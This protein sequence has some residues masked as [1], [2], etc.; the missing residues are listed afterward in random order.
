MGS[1]GSTIFYSLYPI[2]KKSFFI[3]CIRL[4]KKSWT[5]NHIKIIYWLY[6]CKSNVILDCKPGIYDFFNDINCYM[7]L[8]FKPNYTCQLP[9]VSYTCWH[10]TDLIAFELLYDIWHFHMILVKSEIMQLPCLKDQIIVIS[11][12]LYCMLNL[13]DLSFLF[14][15][16]ILVIHYRHTVEPYYLFCILN[17]QPS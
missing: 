13:I 12:N 2:E 16:F 3:L 6:T 5:W 15:N 17:F 7:E 10:D 9:R 14:T 11:V 4:K 1:M 8:N